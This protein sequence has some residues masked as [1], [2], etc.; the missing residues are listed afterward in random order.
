METTY[1]MFLL[2]TEE[3]NFSKAAER[4]FITQQAFSDHIKRLERRFNVTLFQRKPKLMLTPEGKV[5]RRYIL[6]MRAMETNLINELSDISQGVRGTIHFGLNATRG[7]IIVPGFLPEYQKGCPQTNVQTYFNDTSVLERRL[8]N[9]ELDIFLGIETKP[10]MLFKRTLVCKE[11]LYLVIP[12]L[13]LREK[14]GKQYDKYVNLFSQGADLTLL[15]DISFVQS[16]SR[17][18]TT[19]YIHQFLTMYHIDLEIPIYASN[20]DI[21]IEL[22]RTGMYATISPAFHLIRLLQPESAD[23]R[24]HVF[25]IKNMDK[26]LSVE[27]VEHVASQPLRY[28]EK[29]KADLH[30]FLMQKYMYLSTQCK[31]KFQLINGVS[32][33]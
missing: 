5:M 30:R 19:D 4:A 10:N 11:P 15:E 8:I 16:H 21:L 3:L 12:D 24:L 32:F 31:N 14:F 20:F 9:N 29:F 27:I 25:P 17:S 28:R 1:E 13:F 33:K 23:S 6:Q 26:R 7:Q 2:A 18:T 22:C